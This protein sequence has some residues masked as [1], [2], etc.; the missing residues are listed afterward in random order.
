MDDRLFI[1]FVNTLQQKKSR[2]GDMAGFLQPNCWKISNI[3]IE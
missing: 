2:Q 3:S 1:I